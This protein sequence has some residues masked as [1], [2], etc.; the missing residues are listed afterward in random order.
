MHLPRALILLWRRKLLLLRWPR[1]S[2]Q[3]EVNPKRRSHILAGRAPTRAGATGAVA[4]TAVVT[5]IR[6]R[7]NGGGGVEKRKIGARGARRA[8]DPTT[9]AGIETMTMSTGTPGRRGS[10]PAAHAGGGIASGVGGVMMTTP[11]T[12]LPRMPR[13]KIVRTEEKG[14][15]VPV[16]RKGRGTI[17]EIGP[18]QDR[19]SN[20]FTLLDLPARCMHTRSRKIGDLPL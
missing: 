15:A 13:M 5:P 11:A 20:L 18:D 14:G 9:E 6:A 2:R 12:M 7:R 10:I 1:L 16:D 19:S 4:P 17:A 3:L 8:A